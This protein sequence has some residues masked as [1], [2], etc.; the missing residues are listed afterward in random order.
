M[1]RLLWLPNCWGRWVHLRV[2]G[3]WLGGLLWR[4][5]LLG[6]WCRARWLLLLQVVVCG[7]ATWQLLERR[8]LR[9]LEIGGH[10]CQVFSSPTGSSCVGSLGMHL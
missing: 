3:H 6:V 1:G 5:G 4:L 10:H 2:L 8:N 7:Q 9:D